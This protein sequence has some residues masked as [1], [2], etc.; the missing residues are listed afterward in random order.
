MIIS[1]QSVTN[2][3]IQAGA[4]RSHRM[5]DGPIDERLLTTTEL[6]PSAKMITRS[7]QAGPP[8]RISRDE[9]EPAVIR[10]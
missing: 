3:D 4:V 1:V 5:S 10:P 2:M 8:R 7:I 9:R 6:D